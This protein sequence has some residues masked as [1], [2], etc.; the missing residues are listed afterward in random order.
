[1]ST[2]TILDLGTPASAS[3]SIDTQVKC[4]RCRNKHMES[5]RDKKPMP[6]FRTFT[7][8]KSI[9]PRCGCTS[10]Y[11]LTPQVAWCWASG[12]IEIGDELPG[13]DAIE[14]AKGPKYA[15]TGLISTYARHGQGES[16]GKLLVPGVPE[17]ASQ[18]EGLEA[19][20]K[21]LHQAGR[22]AR[23]GVTFSKGVV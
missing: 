2:E 9:C 11:D 3:P 13:P 7:A 1:M 5:E 18:Y 20:N 19:L 4:C 17:A 14:I 15:L 10:Y 21:W 22:R 6:G 8:Y 16:D 23:D 12:L